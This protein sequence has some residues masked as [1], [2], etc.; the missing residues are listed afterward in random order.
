ME[1]PKRSLERYKTN[2]IKNHVSWSVCPSL[3]CL[4]GGVRCW[5]DIF[6]LF[7]LSFCRRCIH[8]SLEFVIALRKICGFTVW[9]VTDS[10]T[11]CVGFASLLYSHSQPPPPHNVC[12]WFFDLLKKAFVECALF[13][14]NQVCSQGAVS[15]TR[16][17][18]AVWQ[19]DSALEQ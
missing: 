8:I 3:L 6:P 1:P 9:R 12:W 7:G 13:L 11:G 17:L 16:P 18:G 4:G 5:E 19:F 15:K 2:Y 10:R 14:N